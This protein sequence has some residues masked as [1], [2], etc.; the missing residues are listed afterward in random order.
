MI[1]NYKT[2]KLTKIFV[3]FKLYFL[4]ELAL[5]ACTTKLGAKIVELHPQIRD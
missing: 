5:G 3:N 4:I 2:A 1:Y